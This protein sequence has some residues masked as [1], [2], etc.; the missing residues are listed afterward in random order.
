M[1][2]ISPDSVIMKM[3]N[4]IK[5][6]NLDNIKKQAVTNKEKELVQN[7]RDQM[8]SGRMGNGFL[9]DYSPKSQT[10][11]DKSNYKATWPTMD[12]YDSGS[13]QDKMYMETTN[14]NVLFDS[15]DSKTPDL[16]SRFSDEIF[17]PDSKTLME[18]QADATPEYNKLVHQAINK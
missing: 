3:F 2:V 18:H 8:R 9:P 17:E 7:Q 12:L 6:I 13:F 4:N 14:K 10:L 1:S 15:R 5:S 16:L 11:K